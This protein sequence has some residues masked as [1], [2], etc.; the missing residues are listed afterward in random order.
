[1][2]ASFPGCWALWL[3]GTQGHVKK[4]EEKKGMEGL[5]VPCRLWVTNHLH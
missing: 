4:Q 3:P 1:M 2:G 5:S